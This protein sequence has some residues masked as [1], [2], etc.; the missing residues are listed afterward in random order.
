M[1]ERG[2]PELGGPMDHLSKR[3]APSPWQRSSGL[4]ESRRY[5]SGSIVTAKQRKSRALDVAEFIEAHVEGQEKLHQRLSEC[6]DY[7]AFRH[8]FTIDKV[9]LHG[10]SFCMKHLLCPLCA[11][12][13]GSKALKAYLDRWEVIQVEKRL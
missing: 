3:K 12:R 9:R 1:G 13:R 11:I 4:K 8:Y 6:G 10:A 7:L 2:F 5:P